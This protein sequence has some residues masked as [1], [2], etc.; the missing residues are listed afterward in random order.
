MGS[1]VKGQSAKGLSGDQVIELVRKH[2]DKTLLSFSRGKD[3]IAAWLAL[4]DRFEA[5]IPFFLD[6][7]PGLEFIEESL[8]YYERF[9]G[10]RIL[11]IVHPST[12]RKLNEMIYQPPERGWIID[13]ADVPTPTYNSIREDIVTHYKLQ[14]DML[15]ATGVRSADSMT[16]RGAIGKYGAITWNQ[17]K[18][19]PIH[20]WS[21]QRLIDEFRRS[22]VKLP[23]DYKLC[24]R[25]IDGLQL[26]FLLPIKKHFPRDYQ[27]ILEL[28]P[29]AELVIYRWERSGRVNAGGEKA[30]GTRE[31]RK[32]PR[33]G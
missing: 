7:I 33:R 28:F 22:G 16:R 23:I 25:T 32:G 26:S 24:G 8:A 31:S 14:S 5:V 9:F 12:F 29:L 11:R 21:K 10:T 20:D 6:A 19:H 27:R 1:S 30:G 3:A 4:R 17:H 18:Y 13:Q 2:Q 15:Y